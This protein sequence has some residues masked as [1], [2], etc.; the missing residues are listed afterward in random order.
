V[1]GKN[2]G[3]KFFFATVSFAPKF[4]R[5]QPWLSPIKIWVKEIV[6][7]LVILSFMIDLPWGITMVIPYKD[8]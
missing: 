4:C 1:P 7:R 5:G 2:N 6:K 3:N 8:M